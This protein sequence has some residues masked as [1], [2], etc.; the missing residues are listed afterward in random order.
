[1]ELLGLVGMMQ[2]VGKV[3]IPDGILSKTEALTEEE[4]ALVQSH[5][6]S[7]MQM[8]M[9]SPRFSVEALTTIASHHERYDGSG[10]PRRIEGSNIGLNAE[11]AGLIDTYCA[12]T[13]QRAYSPAVSSQRALEQLIAMR[14]TKFRAPIV[15]Q[16]IQCVGLY[17]IGT[18]VELNSGEVAV[19]IQQNQVRRLKPRVMIVLAPDKSPERRPRTVDLMMDPASPDGSPYKILRALP[20]DA[21]GI[22]PGEYYIG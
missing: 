17:P 15:D 8:L 11:L 3:H 14:D 10:Y 7:S 9:D 21:Y 12:M 16:L 22:D 4:L 20:V 18:L 2:D 13:R 6:V 19:V 5:V 1:V